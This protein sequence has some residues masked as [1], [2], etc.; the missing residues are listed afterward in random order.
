VSSHN[1]YAIFLDENLPIPAFECALSSD[2]I[3]DY[4]FTVTVSVSDFIVSWVFVNR[5]LL[6]CFTIN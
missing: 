4:Q 5:L 1:Q 2:M 6:V 3:H